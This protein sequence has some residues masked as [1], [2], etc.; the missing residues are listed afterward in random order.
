MA[1]CS[2]WPINWTLS[3]ATTPGQSGPDSDGI[4]GYSPFPKALAL[5]KFRHQIVWCHIQGIR[6]GNLTPQ[7][8]GS[9]CIQQPK[10]TWPDTRWESFH[11]QCI[12]WGNLTPLQR[13]SR[14]ILQPQPTGLLFG[15][16]LTPLPRCSLCIEQPKPTGLDTRWGN[17]HI[18]SSYPGH[19]LGELYLS[20]E[21][22]SVYSPA[23]ADLANK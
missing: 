13:G 18:H 22:Q 20:A 12:R 3:G 23:P 8:R 4:K 1:K 10:P 7:Q 9:Q 19:S 17:F 11:I 6:W 14:C 16:N 21:M 5:L 2:N 15:G